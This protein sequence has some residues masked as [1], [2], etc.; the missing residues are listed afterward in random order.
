VLVIAV[1][2]LETIFIVGTLGCV[3]V[4]AL[5]AIEDLRTLFGRD[6]VDK[7]DD[8]KSVESGNGS[9]RR[10]ELHAQRYTQSLITNH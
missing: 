1:R 7:R 3:V 8:R 10:G 6:D 9:P 2:T 5:T 4:L